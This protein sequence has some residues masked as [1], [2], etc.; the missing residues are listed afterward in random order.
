MKF[1]C[2]T[3]QFFSAISL[4]SRFVQKQTNLPIL[5][6]I[7]L[8]ADNGAIIV[9]AT[10]L[11]CGVEVSV[12]AKV[13]QGGVCAASSA[14]LLGFLSNTKNPTLSG[15]LM[16][17]ILKLQTDRATASIKTIPHAD[18]PTLPRIPAEQSINIKSSDF[19]KGL[20][21]VLFCAA[22]STIKPELQSVYVSGEAGKLYIAATDSFRLAEKIIP[23]KSRGA[24]PPILIPARNA[25]ELVRILE[26]VGG[27]IEMYYTE[28]QIS[29]QVDRV[30]Y[31]SRLLD[32]SFPNYKQIVPK[33]FS[34]EAVVLREDLS[35][36]LKGL[37]VF[38]DK[39]MQVLFVVD[40]KRKVVEL[41]SR[42]NDVGEEECVLKAAVYGEE[43]KMSFN[44]RYL[45]DGLMPI[46]GESVRLQ[47]NGPGKAMVVRDSADNSYTY[48]AMPMN[49]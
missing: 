6:S 1:E 18:F 15:N 14:T 21:S 46:S 30:Y 48:L 22:V 20:R 11:E 19:A 33:E 38:S 2:S 29:V 8:I 42:N 10:N 26:G 39:F 27:D 13:L 49:R 17:G 5:N 45:G 43:V 4:A 9:R 3:N 7:L 40:P 23:L 25:G 36:A 44:S 41:S 35:Q 16:G 24:V 32:G 37:V 34:T 28:N 31:T 12:P 47:A